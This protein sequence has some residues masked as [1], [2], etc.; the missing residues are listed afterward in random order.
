MN[1]LKVIALVQIFI[2]IVLL[3]LL[4]FHPFS[5]ADSIK[6]SFYCNKYLYQPGMCLLSPSI[7]S[8]ILDSKNYLILNFEPLK[9][10]INTYIEKNN[11]DLSM[12]VLDLPSRA[13]FGINSNKTYFPASF[14]KLPIAILILKKVEEGKLSLDTI[15]SIKDSDRDPS[16][17]SLYT[18]NKAQMSV[19]DLLYYMLK[20]S[21]NTAFNTLQEQLTVQD[22]DYISSYLNYDVNNISPKMASNIFLSLYSST[23]LNP[24]D[25]QMILSFLTNTSLDI[26]YYANIPDNIIISHKYGLFYPKETDSNLTIFNDCGIIYNGKERILYCIMSEGITDENNAISSVGVILNGIYN[27]VLEGQQI[28]NI[29]VS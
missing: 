5:T 27:Y 14:N 6:E 25:S 21:D 4:V 17:G 23:I 24:D 28:K 3:V 8:G 2:I 22:L 16:S 13:T 12:Y 10:T 11:L 1:K 20:E 9:D 15:L 26:N 19:R 29:P 18:T 7:N